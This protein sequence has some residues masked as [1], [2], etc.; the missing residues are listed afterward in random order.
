MRKIQANQLRGILLWA[1]IRLH[2]S[3]PLLATREAGP[4]RSLNHT[5]LDD[6]RMLAWI[7]RWHMALSTLLVPMPRP[8]RYTA[9]GPSLQSGGAGAIT[10]TG[11]PPGATAQLHQDPLAT[12]TAAAVGEGKGMLAPSPAEGLDNV[13]GEQG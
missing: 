6:T 13:P 5:S 9:R 12:P 2:L 1:S 10:E 4:S 3:L 7:D 11:A 8:S